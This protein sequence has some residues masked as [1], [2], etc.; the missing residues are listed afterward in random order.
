[1]FVNYQ[2]VVVRGSTATLLTVPTA[3]MKNGDFSEAA[4]P[5]NDPDT[6]D[7]SGR[8]SPFPGNQ[9]P[10]NRWNPVGASL[11]QFY[12]SPTSAGLANNFV[13]NQGQRVS[14]DDLSVKIDRRISDRQN[15]FGRFSLENYGG[16]RPNHFGTWRRRKRARF[17]HGIEARPSTIPTR[18]ENGFFM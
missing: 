5:V 14:A 2:H 16:D 1:F 4:I 15:L 17:P 10:A 12:P 8:R 6:I 7:G 11:L 18:W 3:K 13:S 9:I